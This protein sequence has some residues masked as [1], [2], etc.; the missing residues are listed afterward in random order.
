MPFDEEVVTI[1]DTHQR[2]R[3][4]AFA[5]TA[6]ARIRADGRCL[7]SLL[8]F[9]ELS[10][11]TAEWYQGC[12]QGMLRGNYAPIDSWV[13]QQT[14]LAAAQGFAQCDLI[15]LL[16]IC[17]IT[18]IETE[19]WTEDSFSAV[20]EVIQEVFLSARTALTWAEAGDADPEENVS[21][22]QADDS[23][24][25][26]E[27]GEFS[28]ERRRSARNRLQFPIRVMRRGHAHDMANT[29]SVSRT[30]LYFMTNETYALNERVKINFP[31]WNDPGAINVEYSARVTRVKA[32]EEGCWGVAVTFLQ[33]TA[34]A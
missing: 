32:A 8:P 5:E 17:R 19:K 14:A 1:S 34:D 27:S 10:R 4:T 31:Y 12:A 29:R 13:R 18:A 30:G 7:F 15:Q 6:A 2:E 21:D 16:E 25:N 22:G 28:V 11:L 26:P 9:E 33:T 24:S 20:D 23:S 3:C